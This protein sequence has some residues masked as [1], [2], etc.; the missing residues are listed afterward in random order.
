[1][2]FFM[3]EQLHFSPQFLGRIQLVQGL[4]ELLGAS[5]PLVDN[6]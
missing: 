6:P 5:L 3:T 1:M 4:A 2:F